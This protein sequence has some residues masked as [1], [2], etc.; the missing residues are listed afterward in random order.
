MA[1]NPALRGYAHSTERARDLL[2]RAGYPGGR[3]LPPIAFWSSARHEGILREHAMIKR[4]LEGVGVRAEFSYQPDFP[5]F[6]RMLAEG[7]APVFLHAWHADVPEPDNFLHRLFHSRSPRNYSAYV[8]PAVDDLL[9]RARAEPD[10]VRR[11]ELYRQCEQLILDD[12]P[13]MP[14]F[15]YT[16]E[17]FF[18]RYVKSI[19]VNG[20]GDPYIP[21][22][23]VW[24]E[25][26]R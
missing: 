15:H 13:L 7:K 9:A 5:A 12:A 20:L 14:V 4:A 18:Q 22:R 26:H 16:Y 17:R 8:N 25:A 24:L 1:Y 23:K 10:A 11:V 19:E 21:L 3:G 2:A 6:L